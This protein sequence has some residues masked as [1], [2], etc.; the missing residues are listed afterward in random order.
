M[1]PAKFSELMEIEGFTDE[2]EFMEHCN[3]DS[4]C[5]AICINPGCSNTNE[6]EPDCREGWCEDCNE[7][8]MQSALVILGAI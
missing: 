6:Y 8:T 3:S 5:P 7:N 4:I 2:L 1:Y